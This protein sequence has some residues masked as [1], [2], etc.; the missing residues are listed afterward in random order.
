MTARI[1]GLLAV[2][3]LA[4]S[5]DA[6]QGLSPFSIPGLAPC[7]WGDVEGWAG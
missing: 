7:L 4:V 6:G 1:P 2:G 3:F 5:A